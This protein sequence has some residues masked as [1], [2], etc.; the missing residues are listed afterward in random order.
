MTI[1][2]LFTAS[3]LFFVGCGVGSFLNVV[4]DRGRRGESVRG[5]S[6]CESCKKTLRFFELIPIMSFFAQ[7]GRCRS[8]GIALSFQYP[9]VEFGTGMAYAA[10]SLVFFTSFDY[11]AESFLLLISIFIGIAA[12]IVIVVSDIKYKII[13]NGAVLI[14]FTA[15]ALVAG[16][17]AFSL[18]VQV[19]IPDLIGDT[20]Q[21]LFADLLASLLIAAFFAALWLVSGGRWMG[22]GDAKLVFA[23]SLIVGYPASFSAFLFTFWL[24]GI[25]GAILIFGMKKSRK[26]LIPF[27]PFILAGTIFAYF[28]SHAFLRSTGLLFVLP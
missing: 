3:L 1:V 6:Y 9:L 26:H 2:F 21:I 13:P 11:T 27:G 17:R 5:R 25:A 16:V 23:T 28:F 20:L 4:I 15:G 14:L 10:A 18:P 8:C 24:G 12:S 19:P 22:L 7:K